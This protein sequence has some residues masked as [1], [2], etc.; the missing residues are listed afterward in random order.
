MTNV[1]KHY[2]SEGLIAFFA[3]RE[4]GYDECDSWQFVAAAAP[5]VKIDVYENLI[6]IGEAMGFWEVTQ[7]FLG[8]HAVKCEN[9]FEARRLRYRWSDE[10]ENIQLVHISE[11]EPALFDGADY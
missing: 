11:T 10:L 2:V 3:W 4:R 9:E 6:A 8:K 1:L 7:E 5:R